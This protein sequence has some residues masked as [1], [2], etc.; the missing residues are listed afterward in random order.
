MQF[1][2]LTL[3]QFQIDSI[4]FIEEN[5]SVVVSAATGTGKTLIADYTID[6][7]LKQKRRVVYTAPIKAL[8][9][10]KFKDFSSEYGKEN[11]GIMTGDVV[12]NPQAPI[13]V[14]T[15]EIYRNKSVNPFAGSDGLNKYVFSFR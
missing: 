5:C 1:K 9:N 14:M 15:T 10:Q 4:G 3:D 8:S 11:V 6:K 13:L 7:F 2:G 12:I